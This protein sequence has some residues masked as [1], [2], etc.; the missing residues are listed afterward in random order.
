MDIY[1]AAILAEK[2]ITERPKAASGL[3][4]YDE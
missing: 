1:T 2:L 4:G 3:E